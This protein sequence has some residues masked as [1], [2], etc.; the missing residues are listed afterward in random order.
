M[1]QQIK[2]EGSLRQ[3]HA[4][5]ESGVGVNDIAYISCDSNNSPGFVDPST[6][7]GNVGDVRPKAILLYSLDSQECNLNG[8]YSFESI[9][10]MT[11]ATDS[12]TLLNSLQP[13]N[14]LPATIAVNSTNNANGTANDEST[15]EPPTTNVVAIS[16][17]CS[18]GGIITLFF[19]VMITSYAVRVHRH[20]ERYGPRAH[21]ASRSR[22][23]RAKGIVRAILE[24]LPIVK[25]GDPELVKPDER[26]IELDDRTSSVHH[27]PEVTGS[28]AAEVEAQSRN[29]PKTVNAGPGSE[30]TISTDVEGSPQL[31]P[32]EVE[33][34]CSICTEDFTTGED[35]RVLPCHHKYHPACIEPWLL[36]VVGTCP[37]WCVFPPPFPSQS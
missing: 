34:E 23:T 22:E 21:V 1:L 10:S 36:N 32:Q 8:S 30:T 6:L 2:I 25:F 17:L 15:G 9:Y 18:I 16:L 37:L 7:V 14:N 12:S 5:V 35:V 27:V 33:L 13:N 11:S 28:V 29:P 19:L 26:D 20:P 3:V 24:T 31:T 4:T